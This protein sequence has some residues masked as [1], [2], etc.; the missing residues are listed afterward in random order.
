MKKIDY[1]YLAGFFDGEGNIGI[2]EQSHHLSHMLTVSIANTE[3][4][5]AE[6]YKLALGGSVIKRVRP[7]KEHKDVYVWRVY[8]D[9]A[10]VVLQALLPY[11]K[12]RKAHAEIALQFLEERTNFGGCR[13]LPEA[14]KILRESY[15]QRMASLNKRGK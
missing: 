15:R 14:E 10:K 11:L 5:I 7:K 13:G 8:G 9:N 4:W 1:A 6:W 12:L 2:Y 3:R